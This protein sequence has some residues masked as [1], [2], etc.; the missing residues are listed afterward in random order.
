MPIHR[1]LA[2]AAALLLLVSGT[3]L[4]EDQEAGQ[5]HVQLQYHELV[6]PGGDRTAVFLE[7]FGRIRR[8][9]DLIGKAFDRKCVISNINIYSNANYSGQLVGSPMINAN[10]ALV[11]L[12]KPAPASSSPAPAPVKQPPAPPAGR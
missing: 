3:A 12:A 5:T 9:C 11:L 7:I 1:V 6:P 4:A 8:D 2:A 10:A